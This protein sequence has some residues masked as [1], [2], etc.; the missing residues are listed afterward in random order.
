[1]FIPDGGLSQNFFE[2]LFEIIYNSPVVLFLMCYGGDMKKREQLPM[3]YCPK[4]HLKTNALLSVCGNCGYDL[5][6]RF[7]LRS[8]EGRQKPKVVRFQM[9]Q[10]TH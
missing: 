10:Q 3:I 9:A 2:V 4:C 1:M 6:P 5:T 7:P 8:D